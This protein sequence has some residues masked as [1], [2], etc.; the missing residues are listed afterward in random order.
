MNIAFSFLGKYKTS[1][2]PRKFIKSAAVEAQT[3]NQR[4]RSLEKSRLRF[5]K[6]ALILLYLILLFSVITWTLS[7]VFQKV[8]TLNTYS[9]SKITRLVS[10]ETGRKFSVHKMFRRHPIH[11]LNALCPFNSL[12]YVDVL[13]V[14]F[15]KSEL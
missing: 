7:L 6:K 10:L 1:E 15:K 2:F 3:L 9:C 8:N 14:A 5:A 4:C 12:M 11:L 13:N